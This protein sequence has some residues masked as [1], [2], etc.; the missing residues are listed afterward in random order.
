MRKLHD[1]NV[2]VAIRFPGTPRTHDG[3]H[4]KIAQGTICTRMP[5]PAP[6]SA[7]QLIGLFVLL[8]GCG[9]KP[10]AEVAGLPAA[11]VPDYG[12]GDSYKF[13]DGATDSVVAI[14]RDTVRWRGTSDN[15]ITSRDVLLPRLAWADASVQGERQIGAAAPLLFP[16]RPGK[17]V[18]FGATRTVKPLTGGIP[19]T[20]R[21]NWRC[22]IPGTA[23]I[24]TPAGAFNTW[25]VDCS[26]TE[27]SGAPGS[28]VVQR[29]LY[30]A[31][32][33]GFYVRREERTGADPVRQVE[34]ID[35]T[36]AEP[37]LP[38]S[39]LRLRVA[40]I[41]QA[42]EHTMSGDAVSWHD[43]RTGDDGDV[44]PVKTV[45]SSQYGWCRDF[46]EHIRA[47]GRAYNLEGTGCR[48]PS[49]IWDIVELGPARNRSG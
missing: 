4:Q 31:P 10:P 30:Y 12:V 19:V 18:V 41:Q 24:E 43:P 32:D 45:K 48:N 21:E 39:A 11:P 25:R 23:R 22:D 27:P 5:S 28:S 13:S 35:Y 7:R 47:A 49:G 40:R 33:I 8:V 20:V 15:Y 14:D 16:L 17:S 44:L 9:S 37:S 26:M 6:A 1:A 29:S 42:L 36:S 34:L 38:D 2:R 46:A 3:L